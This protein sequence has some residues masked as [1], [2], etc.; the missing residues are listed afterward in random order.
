M[1]I[2]RDDIWLI[3]SMGFEFVKLLFNPAVFESKGELDSSHIWYLDQLLDL[4]AAEKLPAVACVHPEDDYKRRVLGN[5]AEFERFLHFMTALGRH[6]AARWS[7]QEVALQIMTEP[8]GSGSNPADWNYWNRLQQRLWKSLRNEMPGHTLILSGDLIGSIEGLHNIQPV[9]DENVMYCFTFY[10][11]HLFTWQGGTWRPGTIQHLKGLPYPS[12][13]QTL[14]ELP[15]LLKS[16]PEALQAEARTLVEQYARECWNRKRLESRIDKAMEWR[17]RHG[18]RPRLWCAEFG[19]YQVAAT[20]ADLYRYLSDMRSV[21]EDRR[22]GW[23]CWSYNETFS[24]MTRDSTPFASPTIPTPDRGVLKALLPG[25][26]PG[27]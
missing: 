21:L 12:G 17:R 6:I 13:L 4:A 16:M 15:R 19:C 9:D 25:K 2:G 20:P 7:G 8:Y 26:Y 23:A 11:P 24:I 1:R 10:E 18:N 22:I 27:P 3:R 14:A 5:S